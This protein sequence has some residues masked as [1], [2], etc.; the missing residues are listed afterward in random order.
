[1]MMGTQSPWGPSQPLLILISTLCMTTVLC[2]LP[3]GPVDP[4]LPG[5]PHEDRCSVFCL[6]Q[7]VLCL[8]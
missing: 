3:R 5:E 6:A 1:M 7:R 4:V 2:T 8:A